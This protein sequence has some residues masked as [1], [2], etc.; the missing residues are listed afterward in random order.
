M[1]SI[2]AGLCLHG[3]GPWV[4]SLLGLGTSPD[5]FLAWLLAPLSHFQRKDRT[6]TQQ[7]GRLEMRQQSK[8]FGVQECWHPGQALSPTAGCETL[9][10]L[11]PLSGFSDL[12]LTAS[13]SYALRGPGTCSERGH[14]N[15]KIE[16]IL[17]SSPSPLLLIGHYGSCLRA[18]DQPWSACLP[19]GHH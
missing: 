4:P 10:Q 19:Q 6:Q 5:S 8:K 12:A 3:C 1:R 2:S 16:K 14:H 18:T 11:P 17:P 13:P 9:I 15:F 7:S